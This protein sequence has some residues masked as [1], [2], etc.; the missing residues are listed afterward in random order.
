ML[1]LYRTRLASIN[2]TLKISNT[3]GGWWRGPPAWVPAERSD[4]PAS[5]AA[6][7]EVWTG[8]H[9]GLERTTVSTTLKRLEWK[10]LLSTHC[11]RARGQARPCRVSPTPRD[12]SRGLQWNIKLCSNF[13]GKY[14]LPINIKPMLARFNLLLGL[15]ELSV[16]Y[17]PCRS[18]SCSSWPLFWLSTVVFSAGMV[19]FDEISS[20]AIA[21]TQTTKN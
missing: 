16:I 11:G 14:K 19:S 9:Q 13:C 21:Q 18:S 2:S 8:L 12:S 6:S 4:W 10:D 17:A 5:P 15:K 20:D 1:S 7:P 3:Y